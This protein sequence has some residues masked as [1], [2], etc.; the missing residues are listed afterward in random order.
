MRKDGLKK[1]VIG[2]SVILGILVVGGVTTSA[3][4]IHNAG[5][6]VVKETVKDWLTPDKAT[7]EEQKEEEKGSEE[8]TPAEES[9]T[10]D[11]ASESS[12]TAFVVG[13]YRVVVE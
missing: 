11:P 1:V 7:S 5:G 6:D 4:A 2:L 13:D 3:I 10:T 8:E 9:Q 12:E